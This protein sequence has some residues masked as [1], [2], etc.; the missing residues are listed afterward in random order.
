MRGSSIM[1]ESCTMRSMRSMRGGLF[2]V[3]E[4]P[5]KRY[6]MAPPRMSGLRPRPRRRFVRQWET[7]WTKR[8]VPRMDGSHGA[9]V[10][11]TI[12]TARMLS[13]TPRLLLLL[14]Y[15]TETGTLGPARGVNIG[16]DGLCSMRSMRVGF[17]FRSRGP[18][19]K[20]HHGQCLTSMAKHDTGG[21]PLRTTARSH[22]T[23]HQWCQGH[24]QECTRAVL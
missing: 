3:V 1:S 4:G 8:K 24:T 2:S 12:R 21:S 19:L 11:H 5:C 15:S 6:A 7:A 22:S 23:E 16:R 17:I 14:S 9:G 18:S 20:V 13:L 10:T